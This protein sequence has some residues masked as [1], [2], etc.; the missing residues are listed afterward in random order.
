[1][2][3]GD[4]GMAKRL[5]GRSYRIDGSVIRGQGIGR[6]KLVPTINLKVIQY[7]LPKEGVYATRTYV[8]G[9]WRESV[10]FLGHRVTTDGSFAVE[11]HIIGE[12][13]SVLEH[14]PVWIAFENLI[15][16]NQKFD[17]IE[18]LKQQ[19]EEDIEIRRSIFK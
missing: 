14:E 9:V 16:P 13:V 11:T 17:S 3:E 1:L 12:E 7:Q 15:R 5:L 4:V 19:I 18:A 8:E 6:E 10:S 2:K